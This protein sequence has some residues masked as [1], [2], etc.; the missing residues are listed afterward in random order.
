MAN[1]CPPSVTGVYAMASEPPGDVRDAPPLGDVRVPDGPPSVCLLRRLRAFL[2]NGG[3]R[4][5]WMGEHETVRSRSSA[6]VLL[7]LAFSKTWRAVEPH[8]N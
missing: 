4:A 5:S 7:P 2:S 8:V 3:G 1:V 6:K